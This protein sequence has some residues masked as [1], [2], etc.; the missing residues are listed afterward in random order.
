[1]KQHD[2]DSSAKTTTFGPAVLL[3]TLAVGAAVGF[4]NVWR[5]R[6]SVEYGG[7]AL[8]IPY[9]LASYHRCP[10]SGPRDRF[11]PVLTE[12][13]VFGSFNPPQRSW[14]RQ[15]RVWLMLVVYYSV[16]IAWVI[17]A[18]FDAFGDE[19]HGPMKA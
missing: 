4:W 2:N 11:R 3:S 12:T 1:M 5:F 13:G 18:F 6:S 16:L 17:N 15:C 8:F 19:V 10:Y 9:F 14:C 7:G